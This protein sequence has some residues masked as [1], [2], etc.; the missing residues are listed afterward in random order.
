MA[1]KQTRFLVLLA[2]AGLLV[3][4]AAAA[5]RLPGWLHDYRAHPSTPKIEQAAERPASFP[6]E[7]PAPVRPGDRRRE[8]SNSAPI[9]TPNRAAPP[10]LPPPSDFS[11]S[12]YAASGE[13]AYIF[14]MM[15][16]ALSEDFPELELTEAEHIELFEA[17][18]QIRRSFEDTRSLARSAEN[19]LAF[20]QLERDRE[21][22]IAQFE[23]IIGMPFN[24]FMLRAPI[25]G[26]GFAPD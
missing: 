10:A 16:T 5:W 13:E 15:R 9:E 1:S 19:A 3:A 7:A 12:E 21:A 20:Q 26:S 25:S 6:D 22:A 14:E 24:E 11:V 2:G 23:H 18:A 17:A 4:A 8:A